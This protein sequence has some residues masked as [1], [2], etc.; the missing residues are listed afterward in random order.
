MDFK[1]KYFNLKQEGGNVLITNH[2]TGELKEL[3]NRPKLASLLLNIK[4]IDELELDSDK[5][6]SFLYKD[7]K[8]SIK[9]FEEELHSKSLIVEF[10]NVPTGALFINLEKEDATINYSS[11]TSNV[12]RYYN[13]MRLLNLIKKHSK[14][15]VKDE[16][17]HID[18][19]PWIDS[20]F[21]KLFSIGKLLNTEKR[22]LDT[23]I[24]RDTIN[25]FYYKKNNTEAGFI[26]PFDNSHMKG[27]I[28]Y[29]IKNLTIGPNTKV[30][31]ID[32][33]LL[34][35]IVPKK[36]LKYHVFTKS[37]VTGLM[38][39]KP[40]LISENEDVN[41]WSWIYIKNGIHITNEATNLKFKLCFYASR[42]EIDRLVNGIIF[43]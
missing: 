9:E 13:P 18:F 2:E 38:K 36:Y 11:D 42:N 12:T 15:I 20:L 19:N 10:K 39:F 31:V 5:K 3:R 1:N 29:N 33:N 7:F 37:N 16:N 26:Q 28:K 21:D 25:P 35:L 40:F 6:S 8:K 27:T 22:E 41:T 17:D 24:S 4:K 43:E 14:E 30:I 23:I 34:N 32:N